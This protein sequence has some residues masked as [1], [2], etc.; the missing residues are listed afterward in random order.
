MQAGGGGGRR[1]WGWGGSF[2]GRA[3]YRSPCLFVGA[4]DFLCAETRFDAFPPHRVETC[5][6]GRGSEQ[7]RRAWSELIRRFF[8]GKGNR[9]RSIF[10]AEG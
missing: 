6:S 2:L 3:D 8:P 9:K 7:S 10:F 1:R 5:G 4:A